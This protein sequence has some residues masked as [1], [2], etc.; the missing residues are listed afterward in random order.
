MT[1]TSLN[2]LV[3]TSSIEQLSFET[4]EFLR[5]NSQE[6]L[7]AV[8]RSIQIMLSLKERSLLYRFSLH[9]LLYYSTALY[10]LLLG[11]KLETSILSTTKKTI[12]QGISVLSALAKGS[13]TAVSSLRLI[14]QGF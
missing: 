5:L 12:G 13:Q 6:C 11:A 10:I 14:S 7:V 9:D 4:S 1:R 2:H 3:A 8:R